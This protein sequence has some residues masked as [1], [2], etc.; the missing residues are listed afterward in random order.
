LGT[1][2]LTQF[3]YQFKKSNIFLL[4]RTSNN[5]K[6]KQK[7]EINFSYLEGQTQIKAQ[8]TYGIKLIINQ[9]FYK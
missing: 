1:K 2:G 6:R 4:F 8:H 9:F 5:Y 3:F 7:N